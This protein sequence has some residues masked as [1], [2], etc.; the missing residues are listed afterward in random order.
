M[1]ILIISQERTG[2]L[3]FVEHLFRKNLDEAELHGIEISTAQM[4]ELGS[5]DG[6]KLESAMKDILLKGADFIVVM[7]KWQKELLTRF[8]EY[9]TWS[10]IYLF[11]DGNHQMKTIF[12]PC[13]GDFE[14]HS[15]YEVVHEECKRLIEHLKA[16][17]RNKVDSSNFAVS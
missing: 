15:G 7:E 13:G 17:L 10:K 6:R 5:P 11:A 3:F 8:M 4:A 16:N 9:R 1:K 12:P 2:S 14:Y